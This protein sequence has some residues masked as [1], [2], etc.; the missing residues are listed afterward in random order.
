M[1]FTEYAPL[2]GTNA[3]F[4]KIIETKTMGMTQII[5]FDVLEIN[6]ANPP[7]IEPPASILPFIESSTP[8]D[9]APVPEAEE[10]VEP[11]PESEVIE[12]PSEQ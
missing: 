12:P 11:S 6:A 1:Q 8:P 7:T 9:V 5:S 3:L 10:T 2:S 4:P